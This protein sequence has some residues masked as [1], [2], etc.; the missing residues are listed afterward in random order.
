MKQFIRASNTHSWQ[1]GYDETFP[2]SLVLSSSDSESE[3]SW[4]IGEVDVP[5]PT[6]PVKHIVDCQVK[7]LEETIKSAKAA[8]Y[9]HIKDLEEQLAKLTALPDLSKEVVEPVL[10]DDLPF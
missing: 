9:V 2:Y 5:I 3:Y 6:F 4:V 8:A 7:G 1:N 10:D